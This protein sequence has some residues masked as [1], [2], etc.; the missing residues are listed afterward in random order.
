MNRDQQRPAKA[1]VEGC[2]AVLTGH[3]PHRAA[4]CL[5]SSSHTHR[6]GRSGAHAPAGCGAKNRIPQN[7]ICMGFAKNGLA[8]SRPRGFRAAARARKAGGLAQSLPNGLP[9]TPDRPTLHKASRTA[10]PTPL[11]DHL[12][13]SP[14]DRPTLHLPRTTY[15]APPPDHLPC[16][17]T[18]LPY[19][20]TLLT[21]CAL[22]S[23]Y[24]N[25]P[26]GL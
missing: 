25:M 9:Y 13:Y 17:L 6:P 7:S 15:P 18:S 19:T 11:P 1:A 26:P 22:P 16:T 23:Y 3:P 20:L 12:P 21:C 2:P 14:P 5:P 10:Y 24:V 8:S 4:V